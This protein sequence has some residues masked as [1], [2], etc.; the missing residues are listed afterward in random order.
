MPIKILSQVPILILM[1]ILAG[2]GPKYIESSLTPALKKHI[3]PDVGLIQ[4]IERP[5]AS[6]ELRSGTVAPEAT[7]IVTNQFYDNLV[8]RHV[9]VVRWE[10]NPS[11]SSE[12]KS[13]S[14]SDIQRAQEIGKL[15]KTTTVLF[16]FVS[17]F[18]ERNGSAIGIQSPASVGFTVE[19]I[20]TEDGHLLWKGSYHE[21]QQ[22][23]FADISAWRLFFRRHGRWLTAPEL[24]ED[25]IEQLMDVSP[26]SKTRP[27]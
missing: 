27:G 14:L 3:I 11:L 23:L 7:V 5:Q 24:S 22:T 9:P 4:F 18:V 2:C 16:G 25:G 13:E 26:W 8:A 21:T 19:L 6:G 12:G 1:T 10:G 15:L 20:H 17:T